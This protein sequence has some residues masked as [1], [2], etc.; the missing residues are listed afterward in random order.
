MLNIG[1]VIIIIL[2]VIV[3]NIN[4]LDLIKLCVFMLNAFMPGVVLPNVVAPLHRQV[5]LGYFPAG[6]RRR[7]CGGRPESESVV[8]SENVDWLPERL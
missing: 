2:G 4:L 3:S 8:A 6:R 5:R 7:G 1:M